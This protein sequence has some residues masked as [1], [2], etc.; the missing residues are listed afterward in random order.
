MS[1]LFFES[2][3]ES[4]ANSKKK[5]IQTPFFLPSRYRHI[6]I[7]GV[8]VIILC[9]YYSLLLYLLLLSSFMIRELMI[10]Q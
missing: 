1:G 10:Y 4:Y 5:L 6:N 2:Q 7:V 3:T 9:Y 8:V